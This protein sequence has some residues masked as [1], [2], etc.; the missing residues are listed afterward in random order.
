LAFRVP[1]IALVFRDGRAKDA[2]LL[3]LR[4]ENAVLRRGADRARYEPAG[5]AWFGAAAFSSLG[6]NI[7]NDHGINGE[8]TP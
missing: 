1:W 4:P 3:V 6:D 8:N 7:G 5:R 2:E